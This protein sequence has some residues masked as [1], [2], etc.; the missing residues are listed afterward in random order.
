MSLDGFLTFIG[1]VI[2]IYAIPSLAQ[3][4]SM[5]MFVSWHL[6][7]I[8]V[9][10]SVILLMSPKVLSIFGY[11]LL[12]WSGSLFDLLAFVLPVAALSVGMF[13]WYRAR[14]DDGDDS[15]FRNFLMSCLRENV[16]DEAERILRAN[17]HR[18][19]SVL[20]PDTLQ[21]IFDRKIV[22]RLFQSRSWLHL[23]ILADEQLLSRLP[24][25]HAAVNTV[26]REM[27]VSDESP[28]RAAV[29]GEEHRNYSK[30]QKTLIEAT[31]QKPKW[32]HVSNAHY[33]LVISAMEQLN[34]GKLDS[35]YNRN[36]QNYMAVQ[37]VR[38][39][40][41]CVIWLAIK[42]HVS[43]IRSA[44]KQNYEKDFYISD[45]LQL[46][47]VIRDHSVY[48]ST[49]WEGEKSNFTCPT[50]YSYLL[51]Q[52]SQDFHEL[53]HD[54]VK[55]ATNNGKTDSPNQIVRQIAKCWAFCTCDIA[56]STKNVSESFKLNLIKEHLQF[57]LLLNSGQRS[58]LGLSGQD[59]IG[60]LD[61]WRDHYADTLKEQFINAG[62]DAKCVLQK[63]IGNLD[64]CEEG[65]P[66]LKAT[67]NMS[68]THETH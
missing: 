37:G 23:D 54:A 34:S 1:I 63:A 10:L 48:D 55:S 15:K 36:D 44:I 25:P 45:L 46:F 24:D 17:K 21:L 5:F 12:S 68:V 32:Y 33:P 67:F 66:W 6:L 53:S 22:N 7:L 42:T 59:R 2:A 60:G 31:L 27:L 41:K 4:R 19:Q 49:I 58:E 28:L 47:Q 40:T 65:I 51:Y 30:E 64:L 11:E 62:N 14:L 13:Q 8:P 39:R 35:I 3:R 43:A 61:T 9:L 20:T 50:P 38:S 29:G 57:I 56:R 18:L 16:Y 26:I 52:I